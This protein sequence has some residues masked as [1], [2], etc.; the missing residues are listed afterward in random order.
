VVIEGENV[1]DLVFIDTPGLC[2]QN[3]NKNDII[4]DIIRPVIT[5]PENV[6]AVVSK[7]VA[8]I[9]E[10]DQTRDILD[11][12]FK[13]VNEETWF[14]RSIFLMS[15]IDLRLPHMSR[16][17]FNGY[18]KTCQTYFLNP[19]DLLM[20][21]CNPE[22][23]GFNDFSSWDETNRYIET[24]PKLEREM[25]DKY[26]REKKIP[27]TERKYT[28]IDKLE[29][30]FARCIIHTMKINAHMVI[31]KMKAIEKTLVQN[32]QAAVK[33]LRSSNPEKLRQVLD[34]FR[35]DYRDTISGYNEAKS[36]QDEELSAECS[37]LTWTEQWDGMEGIKRWEGR[38]RW[39]YLLD[40][41]QLIE[42]LQDNNQYDLLDLLG[43]KMKGHSAVKRTIDVFGFLIV[44]AP[45]KRFTVSKIYDAARPEITS[46]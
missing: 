7:A 40:P 23:A 46:N 22:N 19:R 30:T 20:V 38:K 27:E 36:T 32:Y 31:P 41:E 11:S 12:L 28:G 24:I 42:A 9:G 35:A 3:T 2:P 15:G 1:L 43:I 18:R 8:D 39:K 14:Q 34:D 17:G 6:F 16:A 33:V 26:F 45:M 44:A 4:K 10:T 29:K 13:S 37:G 21:S 25:W 5:K